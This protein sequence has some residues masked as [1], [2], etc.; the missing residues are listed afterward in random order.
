MTMLTT[1]IAQTALSGLNRAGADAA[2]AARRIVEG[3]V[4]AK[5]IVDLKL[6]EHAFKA[7]AAVLGAEKR[8]HDR[9]LDIFA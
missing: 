5:D 8:M 7:N 3:P 2:A 4:E 9:L 1:N 6:S